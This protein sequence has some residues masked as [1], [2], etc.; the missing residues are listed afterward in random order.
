MDPSAVAKNVVLFVGDGM[1]AQTVTAARIYKGQKGG[2]DV[3]DK[4]GE[5]EELLWERF[6]AVGLSKVRAPLHY[7]MSDTWQFDHFK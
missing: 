5:G 2:E 7:V 4:N 3:T 1:G 6:P